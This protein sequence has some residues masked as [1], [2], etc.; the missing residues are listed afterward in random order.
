MA[1]HDRDDSDVGTGP[2]AMI[3][4]ASG[5]RQHVATVDDRE[6]ADHVNVAHVSFVCMLDSWTI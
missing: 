4:A 1:V 2:S 3:G 5:Q 6:V